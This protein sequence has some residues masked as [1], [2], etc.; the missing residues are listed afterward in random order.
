VVYTHTLSYNEILLS[1]N[2]KKKNEI[3]PNATI[4]M[5]L[6]HIMLNEIKSEDKYCMLSFTCRVLKNERN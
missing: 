1:N 2:R 6:E 3:L 4:W 5:D